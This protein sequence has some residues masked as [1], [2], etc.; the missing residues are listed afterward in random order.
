M[1]QAGDDYDYVIVGSGAG[2]GTLAARLAEAG[3]RVVV[4]EA[5][6]DP[7]DGA[8]LPEDYDVPAFH[9]LASENPALSWEFF[10][11]HYADEARRRRDPKRQPK[12]IFYPRAGTLGGCTAHNAM[13]L[14]APHDADWDAIAALTGDAS[15]RGAR[16]R[17][18]FQRLEHCR[19]RLFWRVLSWIGLDRTGHGWNGWLPTECAMPWQVFADRRL[20]ATIRDAARTVLRGSSRF[21]SAIMRLVEGL[22]DPND[23]RLLRR[24][25]DGLCF[26]P[27]TTDRHRRIGTRERLLDVASRHPGR[28]HIELHALATRVL[29]DDG[30]R[31]VGVEYLKGDRLYR[32]HPDARGDPGRWRL[33]HAA[34]ADAVGHRRARGAR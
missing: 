9:P 18:Y 7:R 31:A 1:A 32:A 14:M 22:A 4:L 2:G 3:M 12:G 21:L 11:E 5:G 23:W 13:I 15:W 30:N 26:T 33:Q 16:M 29:L 20:I 24:N 10:V 8:G 34:T 27:L 28:L 6:G 17:R 19:Y 25:A